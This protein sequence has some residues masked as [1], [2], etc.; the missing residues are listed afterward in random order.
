[1]RGS[2]LRRLRPRRDESAG[3]RPGRAA[4][5]EL[6][7]RNRRRG[8]QH[9]LSV[10]LPAR[11]LAK[12]QALGDQLVATCSSCYFNL[13]RVNALLAN[14]PDLQ[15]DLDVVLGEVVCITMASCGCVT[16]SSSW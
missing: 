7:R 9:L 4:R 5:L 1:M 2:R 6:L 10:A 15:H 16:C 13:F 8:A 11:N 14:D 12:A 3:Q